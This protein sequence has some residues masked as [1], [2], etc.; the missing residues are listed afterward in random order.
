[1]CQIEPVCFREER[2]IPQRLIESSAHISPC[3]Q[4]WEL[5]AFEQS[6]EFLTGHMCGVGQK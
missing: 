1:M 6:T 4:P 2:E 3:K 5:P